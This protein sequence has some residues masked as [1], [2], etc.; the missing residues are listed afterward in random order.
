MSGKS[1]GIVWILLPVAAVG[2]YVAVRRAHRR[3]QV[4]AISGAVIRLDNDPRKQIPIAHAM[5][6]A[7]D[8]LAISAVTSDS[9]GYFYLQLRSPIKR[10]QPVTLSFRHPDYKPVDVEETAGN[11]IILVHLAPLAA[12]EKGRATGPQIVVG[13][14]DVR[15]SVKTTAV[16]SVGAIVKTF[17]VVHAGTT[18]CDGQ[19]AC[20]PDR[21]WKA[22]TNEL[23]L[24]AGDGN[25]FQG[26]RVSCI[27]GPCPFTLVP[28]LGFSENGRMM[29]VKALDWSDTATFLV[30]AEV[31]RVMV[32][33][34]SV[35]S[36]PINFAGTLNFAVPDGAEGVTIEAEMNGK[37][38]VFPLGPDLILSWADCTS[39]ISNDKA[40]AFRCVLKPGYRFQ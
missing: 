16:E 22:A 27:A 24:D 6:S 35:E 40:R 18:R 12:A 4:R 8:D 33:S 1:K 34:T 13:N 3:S 2:I 32:S 17:Q 9:S 28:R 20:S 11:N 31:D 7:G 26:V 25:E 10:G 5:V 36:F 38:I 37:P 29:R 14:I 15:Y 19:G 21:K 23:D 39:G 30:E